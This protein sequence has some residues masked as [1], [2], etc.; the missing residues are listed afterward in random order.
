M[1]NTQVLEHVYVPVHAKAY[2][3]THRLYL[4]VICMFYT[5][6]LSRE[7]RQPVSRRVPQ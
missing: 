1:I 4:N 7:Q 3:R 5:Q 2:A 6:A